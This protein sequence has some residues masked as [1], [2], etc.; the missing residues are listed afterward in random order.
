MQLLP[1]PALSNIVKHFLILE[2]DT[3]G[4]TSHRMFP[5]GNTG[6]VFHYGTP[7]IQYDDSQKVTHPRSFIYGQVSKFHNVV[8]ENVGVLIVVFQP[9]GA[10]SLLGIPAH[11]LTDEIISLQDLWGREAVELQE[12]VLHADNHLTRICLI[13]K[14]LTN[15]LSNCA[16]PDGVVEKTVQLIYQFHGQVTMG[17]LGTLLHTGERNLERKFRESIGVSPKHFSNTIRLQYFLRLLRNKSQDENLTTLA[18]ESGYYDQAHL[19]R[20][21]KKQVGIT[22]RKYLSDTRLLAVNF[23]QF[24]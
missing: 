7:F 13:E 9:Y 23:I 24:S 6:M 18:Y 4:I 19:I 8:A 3:G 21:F 15:K 2:S 5:D 11:E 17:Q 16:M 20:E 10:Y 1:S 14:F 12:K 22:P